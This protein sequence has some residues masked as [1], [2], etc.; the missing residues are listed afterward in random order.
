M[1]RRCQRAG[2]TGVDCGALG[3]GVA[4]VDVEPIA[5]KFLAEVRAEVRALGAV[6]LVGVLANDQRA[7]RVYSDYAAKGC[8]AAGIDY[9]AVEVPAAEAVAEIRRQNQ[10][11][12]THGILVFYPVFG[13]DADRALQNEV[14][15][16][17]DVEGLHERWTQR[18]YRDIHSLDPEVQARTVLPCTPLGIVRIL[19]ELGVLDPRKPARRRGEGVTVTVFNR[20]EVVG[21]PLLAMLT[22]AGAVVHSFDVLGGARYDCFDGEPRPTTRGRALAESDVVV[23]GV[24][25]R[26]FEKVRAAELREGVVAINFS[27]R[28]NL[29]DDV[30]EHARLYLPRVG[31]VTVSMLMR[32]VVRLYANFHRP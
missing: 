1:I 13:G 12:E 2:R 10:D 31:P 16:H 25:S 3:G 20:S 6:R 24:P 29:A 27:H 4:R 7:S 19:Q 11:P 17:K 15:P 23:T 28:K 18:M 30:V 22:H 5:A 14:D 8:E 26:S 9:A 21:R 32:N